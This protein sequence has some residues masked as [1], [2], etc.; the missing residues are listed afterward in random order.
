MDRD[1]NMV[2]MADEFRTLILFKM[3]KSV[4]AVARDM[5]CRAKRFTTLSCRR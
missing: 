2:Q 3:E 5:M 1:R 4:I